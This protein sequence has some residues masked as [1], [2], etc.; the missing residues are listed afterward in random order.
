MHIGGIC[1]LASVSF[2][3]EIVYSVLYGGYDATPHLHIKLDFCEDP[4]NNSLPANVEGMV[5]CSVFYLSFM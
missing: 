3:Q 4:S 1:I 2:S 5:I